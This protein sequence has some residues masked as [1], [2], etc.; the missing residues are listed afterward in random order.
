MEVRVCNHSCGPGSGHALRPKAQ[1]RRNCIDVSF[2]EP[3]VREELTKVPNASDL[4][5]GRERPQS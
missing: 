3:F 5:V 1:V 4:V 2:P